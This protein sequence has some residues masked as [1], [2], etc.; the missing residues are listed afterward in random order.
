MQNRV[1]ATFENRPIS[2]VNPDQPVQPFSLL[3]SLRLSSFQIGSAM[4]DILTASIWNR[5][6]ISDLGMPATP[7]G[8]LLALQYVMLPISLWIGHRSDTVRF[9][10]RRRDSYI[11]LGRVTMVLAFPLLGFSIGRFEQGSPTV[12][13]IIAIIAFLLFGVG[14]LASGSVY[15]AHVRESAPP[16]K[17]GL[18]IS[19]AET[20]LITMYPLIAIIFGR[21]M[22]SYNQAI[23]WQLIIATMLVG[24]FFWFVSILGV[25]DTTLNTNLA[26]ARRAFNFKETIATIWANP[27][28]R[29]FF[30][31]LS[32][33]TFSA[34]MQDNILEPFGGD[35][36][37][38]TPGDTTRFTGYWGGMTVI[39]AVGCFII[40]RNQLAEDQRG[41][42]SIGLLI[43]AVGLAMVA[44]AGFLS[45]EAYLIPG[46]C[47]FGAG[48]GLYTFGGLSL[49]AVMSPT[50]N[51]GAYLGLWT[52]CILLS[53][54]LGTFVGG[55]FRD[56]F[57]LSL[58]MPA[59]VG[60]GMIFLISGIG[61]VIAAGLV[62]SIDFHQFVRDNS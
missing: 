19:L 61:L 2:V 58:E 40:L 7:V 46:L 11:W 32:L 62:R 10:G 49:M 34:W 25:E 54:G 37:A 35:V 26:H 18:A 1:E 21:W 57:L 23:F 13:W 5:V 3:R 15:L 48:F 16:A 24:G 41:L 17:R 30:V 36:F 53:K 45:S 31:F 27:A 12:G 52:L 60:Y 59:G 33:A 43:M 28:T 14:K 9:F 56:I 39:V 38:L 42:T 8:L 22:E 4:G 20:A 55:V 47:V 44:L 29:S 51:A 50:K 6:M